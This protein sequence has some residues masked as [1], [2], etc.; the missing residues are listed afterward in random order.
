MKAQASGRFLVEECMGAPAVHLRPDMLFSHAGNVCL[1]DTKWKVA[2]KNGDISQ[3]DIYQMFAY[4]ETC[5]RG[6]SVKHSFLIYPSVK[7]QEFPALHFR[8]DSSVLHV[9]TY[10]LEHDECGL[11]EWL[12][13]YIHHA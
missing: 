12:D 5:L 4:T 11:T 2:E 6:Q 1:A 8:R 10:D 9:L 13:E 7:A 3:A